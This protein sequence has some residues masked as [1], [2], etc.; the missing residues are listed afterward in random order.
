MEGLRCVTS[1]GFPVGG[2]GCLG[3]EYRGAISSLSMILK[4]IICRFA[5]CACLELLPQKL[6]SN[7]C[8]GA[9]G[10]NRTPIFRLE[11]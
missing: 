4:G 8:F 1:P 6:R 9:G 7:F 2:R 3:F 11:I 5:V 10:G